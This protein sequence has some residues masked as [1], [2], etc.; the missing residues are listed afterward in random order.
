M[1]LAVCHSGQTIGT[2][3]GT[4]QSLDQS[5]YYSN[6]NTTVTGLTV[7]SG[8]CVNPG[9]SGGAEFDASGPL[10]ARIPYGIVG[11]CSSRGT[12]QSRRSSAAFVRA[13]GASPNGRDLN[14]PAPGD[15][16]GGRDL[17]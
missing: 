11:R 2:N 9:D 1:G 12:D 10:A 7:V 8:A 14:C 16:V 17:H 13:S 3:C 15:G 4:V 6:E 5:V